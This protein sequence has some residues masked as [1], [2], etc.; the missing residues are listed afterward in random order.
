MQKFLYCLQ[1]SR[2][3]IKVDVF[4]PLGYGMAA[5]SA[6][7]VLVSFTDSLCQVEQTRF[8]FIVLFTISCSTTTSQPSV[9]TGFHTIGN[10][11]SNITPWVFSFLHSSYHHQS[12]TWVLV[13]TQCCSF[14]SSEL[15]FP[16]HSLV[17]P[18]PRRPALPSLSHLPVYLLPAPSPLASRSACPTWS[19]G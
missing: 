1:R 14:S 17:P 15:P 2:Y 9:W 3:L 7:Q 13:T 12:Q 18:T 11:L 19:P 6:Q 10:H 16:K 4:V 5:C 8:E